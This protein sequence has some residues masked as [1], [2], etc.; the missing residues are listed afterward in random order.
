[1]FFI[2]NNFLVLLVS[3]IVA[4][5]GNIIG[6]GGGVML[7]PF[8]I[9]YL[10]LNSIAAS[11]L[12]LFTITISTIGGTFAFIRQKAI[13]YKL[14]MIIISFIIPGVIVGSIVNR[15]VNTQ[16]F[17]AILPFWVMSVGSFSLFTT[18]KQALKGLE[19]LDN[20]KIS[21]NKLTRF[22]SFLSGFVSGF[23]GVGIGGVMGTYLITVEQI[24]ARIAFSTLIMVMAIT[25]LIGFL[26]HYV[27]AGNITPTW[28]IYIIPLSLG[29]ILGSQIGAFISKRANIK[30]LRLYQGW[31]ILL[32][33]IALLLVDIV[34]F[35]KI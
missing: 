14:F 29:A 21:H 2:L 7:L 24:S 10:H 13:N 8:F 31:V 9:F 19:K 26:A 6:I 12:G 5:I 27:A 32:L 23:F 18:K 1:M 20:E 28:I 22:V 15:F 17:K 3:M 33:G 30:T 16:E 35:L 11:G 34:N 4:I 25:S